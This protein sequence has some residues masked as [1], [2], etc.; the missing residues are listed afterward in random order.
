MVSIH[1]HT[2]EE[3]TTTIQWQASDLRGVLLVILADGEATYSVG[4]HYALNVQPIEWPEGMK[5]ALAEIVS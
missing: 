1:S 3:G 5:L 2:D 4:P